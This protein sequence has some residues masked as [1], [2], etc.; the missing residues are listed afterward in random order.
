[1]SMAPD[2]ASTKPSNPFSLQALEVDAPCTLHMWAWMRYSPGSQPAD[3]VQKLDVD[4]C[5]TLGNVCV[6]MRGF[7]TLALDT[8]QRSHEVA[9][10]SEAPR[11]MAHP[12]LQH[13]LSRSK[14]PRFASV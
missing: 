10:A 13:A 12:L 11:A 3:R 7:S 6:R 2:A 8:Q 14:A 5:D 9:P 4:L 1:M